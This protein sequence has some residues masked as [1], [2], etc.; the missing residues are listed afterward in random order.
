MDEE[1]EDGEP[2]APTTS[3]AVPYKRK[4]L[5]PQTP[6][7]RTKE[8]KAAFLATLPTAIQLQLDQ[9]FGKDNLNQCFYLQKIG[10]MALL[11]LYKSGFM[12]NTVKKK[13]ERAFPP[14]RQLNQ[15]VKLYQNVDFQSMKGFQEGWQAQTEL[16]RPQRD[17][18]TAC[19][20]HFNLSLPA[21]VRWIGGPHVGEH[22]DNEAIFSRLKKTCGSEV[23]HQLVRIFTQGSPT[24]VNA[25]CS[26]QNYQAYKE[27]GNHSTINDNQ[28]MVTK[29]LLKEVKRGCSL[30]LD[31]D[32]MVFL[33]NVKQTPHGI[34]YLDYPYK[35]LRVVWDSSN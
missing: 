30:M 33:E 23:Y 29:T 19:L 24:F 35:I 2:I 28:A 17:M 12:S 1:D 18:T 7:F 25:E 34:L 3:Q 31:P 16:S 11:L 14:A 9:P 10:K 21:M 27:Y 13:L 4:I 5:D 20:I 6:I 26:Q 32:A 22:R 15:I 8:S